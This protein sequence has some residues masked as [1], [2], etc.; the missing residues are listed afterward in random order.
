MHY[1]NTML[2]RNSNLNLAL[3]TLQQAGIR[4]GA[5]ACPTGLDYIVENF[6]EVT[7]TWSSSLGNPLA[8]VRNGTGE[9]TR[10]QFGLVVAFSSGSYLEVSG[11]LTN[12]MYCACVTGS[13]IIM[14][15]AGIGGYDWSILAQ[16]GQSN[17]SHIGGNVQPPAFTGNVADQLIAFQY[18]GVVLSRYQLTSYLSGIRWK[19]APCDSVSFN[20]QQDARTNSGNGGYG[21]NFRLQGSKIRAFGFGAPTTTLQEEYSCRYGTPYYTSFNCP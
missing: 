19:V 6:D 9:V 21:S 4:K 14:S 18:L 15:G 11:S 10:D 13:S 8:Y 1:H 5:I 7:Q 17:F 12:P 3:P 16:S 2:I 20:V